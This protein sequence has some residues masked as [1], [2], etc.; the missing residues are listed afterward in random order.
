MV[1]S[2]G[3]SQCLRSHSFGVCERGSEKREV[4]KSVK[5]ESGRAAQSRVQ[6]GQVSRARHELT[7][8]PLAPMRDRR[9]REQVS[10]IPEEVLEFNPAQLLQLEMWT[11]VD[12]M[13]PSGPSMH[14]RQRMRGKMSMV[15]VGRW[16]NMREVNRETGSCLSCSVWQCTTLC[17][18]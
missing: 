17:V 1:C 5:A 12:P 15:S 14:I 6:Q 13:P 8:A 2:S 18:K 7:G 9:P 10:P 11:F 4:M 16:R 3:E